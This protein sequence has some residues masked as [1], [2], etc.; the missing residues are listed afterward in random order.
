MVPP[1]A[2]AAA[3]VQEAEE[4]RAA[5]EDG[6]EAHEQCVRPLHAL[7]PRGLL[8]RRRRVR[9]DPH[10]EAGEFLNEPKNKETNLTDTKTSTFLQLRTNMDAP[11]HIQLRCYT[12]LELLRSSSSAT[13]NTI[14][15][16]LVVAC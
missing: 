9:A 14:V 4:V 3:A 2:Q 11:I 16:T 6:H 1:T 13:L 10:L 5:Q 15:V 8:Q 7:Q 12:V